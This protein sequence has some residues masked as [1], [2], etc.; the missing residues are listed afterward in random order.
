[1]AKPFSSVFPNPHR[2]SES[3]NEEDA[4]RFI[5]TL[6]RYRRK[7]VLMALALLWGVFLLMVFS[8]LLTIRLAFLIF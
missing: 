7:E 3:L 4:R 6:L 1:M 5:D 2:V 8:L